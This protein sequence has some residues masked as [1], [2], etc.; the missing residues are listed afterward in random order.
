MIPI[1]VYLKERKQSLGFAPAKPQGFLLLLLLLVLL[2]YY[3]SI[4]LL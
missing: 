2:F 4:L 1:E 3:D